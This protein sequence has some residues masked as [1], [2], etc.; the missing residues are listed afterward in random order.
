MK[1]IQKLASCLITL[2]FYLVIIVWVTKFFWRPHTWIYIFCMVVPRRHLKVDRFVH[3]FSSLYNIL[4]S[5]VHL[6]GDAPRRIYCLRRL[7]AIIN[8]FRWPPLRSLPRNC[9]FFS[10]NVVRPFIECYNRLYIWCSWR[11]NTF[12]KNVNVQTSIFPKSFKVP[13]RLT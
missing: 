5:I 13:L 11:P 4:R 9:E 10:E 8:F 1:P 6:V 3:T 2:W 12:Q 7:L